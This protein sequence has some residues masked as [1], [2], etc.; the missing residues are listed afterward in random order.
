MNAEAEGGMA[1]LPAVD[2]H[3]VRIGEH[4]RIA[5]GGGKAQHT[6]CP[7]LKVQPLIVV[8]L[9]TTRAIVTGA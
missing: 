6:I 8:S 2:D 1:I 7:S 4:R 5:I 3:L 9:A